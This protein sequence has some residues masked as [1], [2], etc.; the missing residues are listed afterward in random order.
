MTAEVVHAHVYTH[1]LKH[2]CTKILLSRE[3]LVY[4][5]T[6]KQNMR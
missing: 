6:I 4:K 5:S 2:M 1:E 3:D